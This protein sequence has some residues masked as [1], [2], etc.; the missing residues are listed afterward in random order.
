MRQKSTSEWGE[1]APVIFVGTV[2]ASR[3][4]GQNSLS[5]ETPSDMWRGC[6]SRAVRMAQVKSEKAY[7]FS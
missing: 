7:T 2:S 6:I 5:T 4:E 3:E 1:P